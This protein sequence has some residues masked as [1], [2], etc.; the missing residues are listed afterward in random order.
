MEIVKLDT[1][2]EVQTV[3]VFIGEHFDKVQVE[4]A[5]RQLGDE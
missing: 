3:A 4:Q 2:Q 1:Q 5:I